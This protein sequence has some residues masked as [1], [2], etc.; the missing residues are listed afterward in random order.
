MEGV[1]EE[2]PEG[3]MMDED[4]VDR[5]RNREIG[6]GETGNRKM[7]GKNGRMKEDVEM[8]GEK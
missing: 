4:T 8:E 5:N 1:K 3:E 2:L 7:D 6:D